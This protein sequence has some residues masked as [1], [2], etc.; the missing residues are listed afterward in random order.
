MLVPSTR[1]SPSVTGSNR[2]A[3]RNAVVLP[4]PFGPSIATISVRP[5]LAST[6]LRIWRSPIAAW[7]PRNS[8]RGGWASSAAEA[9]GRACPGLADGA[10]SRPWRAW[11]STTSNG[12]LT[13]SRIGDVE[14]PGHRPEVADPALL[15]V[16]DAVGAQL[17]RL[18]HAVLD[19]DHRVA[20]VGEH[21]QA[22]KE[23]LRGHRIEVRQRLVDDVQ[24]GLHHQDPGHREQLPLAARQLRGHATAQ[25]L[26]PGPRH[27]P[28]D[29]VADDRALDAEV[30]GTEREL[31][32]DRRPDDLLGR[33][34]QHR[35]DGPPDVAQLRVRRERAGDPDGARTARPGRRAGSGR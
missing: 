2:I 34:L 31:R 19:D 7:T 16:Q 5:R 8:S 26:E 10:G 23:A 29:P 12:S 30:L 1:T 33:I 22:R 28:V 3:V 14:E 17:E 15:E 35:P 27:D 18:L 13:A 32:L 9:V 4:E 11:S 20:G 24:A 6:P 25:A 21:P